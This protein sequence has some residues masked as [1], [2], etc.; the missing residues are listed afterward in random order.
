MVYRLKRGPPEFAAHQL[1]RP[2]SRSCRRRPLRIECAGSP[3]FQHINLSYHNQVARICSTSTFRVFASPPATKGL[4]A[5]F[6]GLPKICDIHPGPGPGAA[7]LP[8]S[9]CLPLGF[10]VLP[11]FTSGRQ[12]FCKGNQHQHPTSREKPQPT[13]HW[14]QT[15]DLRGE[16]NQ[17]APTA[18]LRRGTHAHWPPTP[19]SR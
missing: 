3:N 16:S 19:T 15:P 18:L 6:T 4:R 17:L 8:S 11:G 9:A 13:P 5:F 14:P 2:Q 10:G 7:P 12:V 1:W